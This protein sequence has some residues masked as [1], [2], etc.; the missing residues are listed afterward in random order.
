MEEWVG[1]HWHRF[2]TNKASAEYPDAQVDLENVSKSVGILFRALGGEASL[3]IEAASPRDYIVRRT[4]LQKFAGSHPQQSVAWRDNNSLRLPS[5]ISL[6]PN[7][8]LNR[9][10]YLWL[11]M[12]AAQS[13]NEFTHWGRDNQAMVSQLI[14]RYPTMANRYQKLVSALI[15]LRPKPA[16]LPE[17]EGRLELMI[18]KAL[19]NPGSVEDFPRSN[20][21]PA[22]VPLWLY[23]S[24]NIETPSANDCDNPNEEGSRSEK[25]KR[26]LDEKKQAEREEEAAEKEGILLFRLESLFSWSEYLNL[27]RSPDD[28]DEDN[29]ETAKDL[30]KIT[31]S[32]QR[33]KKSSAIKLNLDL[34]AAENDDSPLGPGIYLPE[35]DWRK[36]SLQ[37]KYVCLQSFLPRN[38]DPAPLP[39]YLSR[40]ARK[41]RNQFE[42]L[43]TQRCWLRAQPQGEELDLKNW[44]DF[45]SESRA[46]RCPE[47]G[48]YQTFRAVNRDLATLL[49]A[50]LSMST[51]AYL[52]NNAC[53]IDVIRDGLLLCGEALNAINDPF[54]IYGFSSVKRHQVRYM[55]LKNFKEKYNNKIRGRISAIRP[56]Y[57]TRM[58]AAIRQ[59]TKILSEQSQSRRLL[60]MLT[61]GKPNDIDHYEGRYGIEDTRHA[62]LEAKQKGLQ[63]FCITI[64]QKA[65]EYLPYLFGSDG[66]TVLQHPTHLPTRLPELY[67]QLTH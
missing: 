41:I 40:A 58:G 30:D 33:D 49:L 7:K 64:D 55:L 4:L 21:A 24:A 57:Y 5:H 44:I 15:P 38:G 3:R 12:L 39:S 16:S 36:Q 32:K 37:D 43:Q 10:L 31:L 13:S 1:A 35:W 23:P 17:D 18:Q 52:D 6:F 8:S 26:Q 25:Q 48:L 46:G 62:I 56:G 67:Y 19:R 2:I 54:A 61:D 47:Q 20:H 9:E 28:S 27:Q 59:S 63:V 60:L 29:L 14:T 66:F 11:A 22:P 53:V 65:G 51:E 34:P 50:D 45:F 42:L